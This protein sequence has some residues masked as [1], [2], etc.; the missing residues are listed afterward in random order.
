M[1]SNGYNPSIISSDEECYICRKAMPIIRHEIF[2]GHGLRKKSKK[3]GLWLYLCPT[4]HYAIH[5]DPARMR[6]LKWVGQQAA[7]RWYG[8]DEERFRKE[9]YKSYKED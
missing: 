6:A 4:C 3:L 1:D 9:F 5:N 8:W 2:N 7:M